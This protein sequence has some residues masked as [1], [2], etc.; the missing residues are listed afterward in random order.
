MMHP[1]NLI[2]KKKILYFSVID[3]S[4]SAGVPFSPGQGS[5]SRSCIRAHIIVTKNHE[6]AEQILTEVHEIIWAWIKDD[7]P[8]MGWS[9]RIKHELREAKSTGT[10]C[11]VVKDWRG[12]ANIGRV[13][14]KD[15]NGF[16]SSAWPK[17]EEKLRDMVRQAFELLHTLEGGISIIETTLAFFGE[18]S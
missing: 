18:N 16:V 3:A 6:S 11:R 8:I 14:L 1:P 13:L 4:N 5:E 7:G 10:T 17:D 15:L 9:K 12:H 2:P